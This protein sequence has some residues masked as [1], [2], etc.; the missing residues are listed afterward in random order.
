MKRELI[1]KKR[2]VLVL[3]LLNIIAVFFAFQNIRHVLSNKGDALINIESR[4]ANEP[5]SAG[6]K[7]KLANIKYQYL[8]AD[9]DTLLD[10]YA[11]I[12]KLNPV[13]RNSWV[14]LADF[15]ISENQNVKA[16]T[17]IQYLK[18]ITPYGGEVR[19]DISLQLLSIG[20]NDMAIEI[21]TDLAEYDDL[22]R[23]H[24]LNLLDKLDVDKRLFIQGIKSNS[25][26]IAYLKHLIRASLVDESM[27][28]WNLISERNIEVDDTVKNGFINLLISKHLYQNA[29]SIWSHN[30]V[31]NTADYPIWNGGFE[32][33]M[34]NTG[35]N[36]R[37]QRVEDAYIDIDDTVYYSGNR[38]LKISFNG[39]SNI[40]FS[41]VYKYVPVQANQKY[42]FSYWYSSEYITT[43][44]GVYMIL[45]CEDADFQINSDSIYG[46]NIWKKYA[47]EF[48]TPTGCNAMKLIV[49][50]DPIN[51]LDSKINGTIWFD[52][53]ALN[54]LN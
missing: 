7:L 13:L 54:E 26:H 43:K 51:K 35:F 5:K 52:D 39:E 23:G 25:L 30:R 6:L 46:S 3:I 41:H 21:L 33:E 10:D 27:Y 48:T 37:M 2:G 8:L 32:F 45:K 40:H 12:L 17:V 44:S 4:V 28:L 14:A 9:Y 24:V 19:W 11:D 36:W 1:V 53:V 16:L 38:S 47:V 34:E 50:R 49:A 42:I 22:K 31:D 29:Y 18:S 15:L 20:K